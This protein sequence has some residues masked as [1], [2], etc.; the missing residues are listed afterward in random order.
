MS[1]LYENRKF[2]GLT[3]IDTGRVFQDIECRKCDFFSSSISMGHDLARRSV[4]RRVRLRDCRVRASFVGRAIVDEV[5]IDGMDT[6]KEFT[7]QCFATV[8]RHVTLKGSIGN[9]QI[10]DQVGLSQPAR[11]QKAFNE[12]NAAFYM[13]VDWALDISSA[14]FYGCDIRGVPYRLVRRDPET[15]VVITR[16]RAEVRHWRHLDFSET[17]LDYYLEKLLGSTA[18]GMVLVAPK[19]SPKFK[20]FLSTLKSLREIGVALPD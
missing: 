12:A 10:I 7:L 15:Q 4:V 6:G 3:D 1:A 19:A 5:E 11:V 18:E 9:L 20:V 16:E 14:E 17:F 13:N 2:D 8:L